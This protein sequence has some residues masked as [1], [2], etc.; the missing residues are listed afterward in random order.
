[1]DRLLSRF[2]VSIQIGVIAMLGIAGL[3]AVGGAYLVSDMRL[4]ALQSRFDHQRGIYDKL[5]HIDVDLLQ[6]RRLEKDFLLRKQESYVTRHATL[7]NEIVAKVRGLEA[8]VDPAQRGQ[9]Q[10]IAS[11]IASYGAA[12]AK[13]AAVQTAL[14]LDP[15]KGLE[16]ALRKSVQEVEALLAKEDEPRLSVLMLMMRRHEKDFM[17]RLDPRYIDDMKKRG[18]EFETRLAASGIAPATRTEITA[19]M[20]AYHRDFF[21]FTDGTVAVQKEAKVLSDTYAAV[22]PVLQALQKQITDDYTALDAQ[23]E[24]TRGRTSLVMYTA[25][26]VA[27]LLVTLL[28]VVVARGVSR[29]IGGMTAAM[30]RLAARD[31]SVAIPGIGRRDELGSMASAVQV[32]KDSMIESERLRAEQKEAEVRAEAEKRAAMNKLADEFEASVKGV[33]QTVSSA[34][35]ELQSTAQ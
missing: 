1:M 22:E 24:T 6:A 5:E 4:S 28:S 26:A 29:P 30:S 33:V 19:K 27:T 11:G 20:A 13:L 25:A 23:M 15:S 35:T 14:G 9:I 3:L 10:T 31:M 32:F 18:A 34:A 2:K 16:G 17:L 21:S 7:T 8:G 12:F